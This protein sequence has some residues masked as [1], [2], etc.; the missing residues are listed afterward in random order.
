L[1]FSGLLREKPPARRR[2]SP[3]FNRFALKFFPAGRK[4]FFSPASPPSTSSAS[5]VRPF[6]SGVSRLPP[7]PFFSHPPSAALEP[8]SFFFTRVG[9][10]GEEEAKNRGV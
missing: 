10:R 6:F 4:P 5:M 9:P 8:F 2:D 1:F 3:L 7:S